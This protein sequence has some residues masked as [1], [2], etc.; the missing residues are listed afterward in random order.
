MDNILIDS[1]KDVVLSSSLP[2][3]KKRWCAEQ[4]S[5][6]NLAQL[7]IEELAK[8]LETTRLACEEQKQK[9]LSSSDA[10]A[11]NDFADAK[12]FIDEI[13]EEAEIQ[14]LKDV[15]GISKQEEASVVAARTFLTKLA[16]SAVS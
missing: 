4:L 3:E 15:G 2:E 11:I 7:P 6:E 5:S 1:L 8:I 16:A 13:F 14:V 9:I 12:A 10:A